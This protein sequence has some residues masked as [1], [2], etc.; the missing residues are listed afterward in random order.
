LN[1]GELK[2]CWS[3]D[4][5]LRDAFAATE[6]DTPHDIAKSRRQL[7]RRVSAPDLF[8]AVTKTVVPSAHFLLNLHEGQMGCGAF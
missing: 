7:L 5:R 2:S 3:D 4:M 8:E 6:S 1:D